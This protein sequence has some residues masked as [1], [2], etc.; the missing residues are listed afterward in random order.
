MVEA[1]GLHAFQAFHPRVGI[2]PAH[3]VAKQIFL[4]VQLEEMTGGRI[5][6]HALA[7]V[8][9]LAGGDALDLAAEGLQA[10]LVARE[11]RFV[12]HLEAHGVHAGRVGFAQHHG[13][14]V[15]FIPA[16]E[17]DAAL[18][19]ARGFDETNAVAVVL[20]RGLE[21]QHSQAH[22]SRT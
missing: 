11:M 6:A 22:M 14:P 8:R 5:E 2:E 9:E 3:A 4:A 12:Q 10:R 15:E 20:E 1:L 21:V 16:F 7:A 18:R 19:V 17:I 13:E